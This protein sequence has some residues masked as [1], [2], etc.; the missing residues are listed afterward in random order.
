M[1]S[2]V[3]PERLEL[4]EE[5]PEQSDVLHVEDV[6]D[7]TDGAEATVLVKG[8]HTHHSYPFPALEPSSLN[9]L[10]SRTWARLPWLNRRRLALS[11][12]MVGVTRCHLLILP[13]LCSQM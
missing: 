5:N 12:A 6:L 8:E 11:L 1:R 9:S 4:L 2:F 13:S 7:V 10:L 3:I